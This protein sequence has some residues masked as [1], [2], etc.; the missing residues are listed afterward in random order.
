MKTILIICL[1]LLAIMCLFFAK[2]YWNATRIDRKLNRKEKEA[3]RA[4]I[5]RLYEMKQRN[6]Q[7][8]KYRK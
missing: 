7:M 5:D 3:E 8:Q 2:N 4:E 6:I 1:I